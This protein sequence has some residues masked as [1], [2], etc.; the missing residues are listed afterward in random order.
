MRLG[1]HLLSGWAIAHGVEL[2][3]GRDLGV[4][5]RRLVVGASLAA[6]ADGIPIFMFWD[7][8]L[9]Q[10][11]HHEYT[12]GLPVGVGVTVLCAALAAKG[13]RGLTAL[14]CALGFAATSLLDMVTTNWPVRLFFPFSDW[15]W[16]VGDKLGNFTIYWIIGT[17][18][19]LLFLGLAV[20]IYVRWKRT[21]LELLGRRVERVL[22][23][24][25]R[26]PWRHRCPA[27]GRR[28]TY[29]CRRCG[30]TVCGYHVKL[31]G[32]RP[33]CT[34]CLEKARSDA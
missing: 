15:R 23:E 21:P 26:L 16:S 4:R 3:S 1:T 12:A 18:A 19:D 6:L 8:D 28:A 27:C 9:F 33:T 25:A 32:L 24:F 14:A 34:S 5:G 20:A 30:A 7:Q 13:K 2:A 11:I 31:P 22:L 17:A 10:R 29:R